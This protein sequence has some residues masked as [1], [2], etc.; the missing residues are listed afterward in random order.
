MKNK[1]PIMALVLMLAFFST[2]AQNEKEPFSKLPPQE[3][4]SLTRRLSEYV[5]AHR[6]RN[7]K[8]LYDLVSD[9]GK[10]GVNRQKFIAAM[11]AK[12]GG[13]EYSGMPDLLTFTPNRTDENEDGL[14][15][16]G[17]GKAK[18]E[19]ESYTGIAVIHAVQERSTWSF[20]GWS[21]TEFPNEPC[22][23]LSDPD[24]KPQGQMEWKQPMEELRSPTASNDGI[25]L[26]TG[27]LHLTIP[28]VTM[29]PGR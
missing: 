20:S 6:T 19:G 26:K 10:N 15:I 14:D 16:Y 2:Y 22:S 5:N 25:D 24:W 27:N 18:R 17:C 21:F 23:R 8:T 29:N 12:H 1:L 11:K 9:T 28:L 7:W 4:Q 3:Q 13:K